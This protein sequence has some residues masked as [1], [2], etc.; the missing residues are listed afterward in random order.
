MKKNALYAALS[1][2][3]ALMVL[4]LYFFMV[5]LPKLKEIF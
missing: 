5:I 4:A 2:G 3:W 1:L